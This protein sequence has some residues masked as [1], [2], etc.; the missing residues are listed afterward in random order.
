MGSAIGSRRDW[1]HDR[2]W[3]ETIDHASRAESNRA[4]PRCSNVP[5]LSRSWRCGAASEHSNSRHLPIEASNVTPSELVR[6]RRDGAV[7]PGE[8]VD[9][10]HVGASPHGA[11]S[12]RE[13]HPRRGPGRQ[14]LGICDSMTT[15]C[16]RCRDLQ[17]GAVVR[18][19]PGPLRTGC[20]RIA[21][22]TRMRL[23]DSPAAA[24]Q[25]AAPSMSFPAR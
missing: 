21:P 25:G 7:E 9:L 8:A 13:S 24:T 20:A 3:R 17:A 16:R 15:T 6:Q 4:E 19:P 5:G 10:I 18:F 11:I 14:D 2:A 22:P 23:S 1:K 12:R